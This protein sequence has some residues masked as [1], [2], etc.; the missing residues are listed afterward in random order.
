MA[1][2]VDESFEVAAPPERVWAY[3][4]DP[5]RV[6]TCLPGAELLEVVDERTFTGRVKIKVGPVSA[7]FRGRATFDEIDAAAR[8]VRMSGK[9]QEMAGAGSATMTMTSEVAAVGS[10]SSHVKVS[11]QV[12]VVGRLMQFGRGMMEE[13]SRQVFSQFAGCVRAT[14]E[15]E[16]SAAAGMGAAASGAGAPSGG[17][18]RSESLDALPLVWRSMRNRIGRL[19]GSRGGDA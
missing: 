8:R 17:A 15:S 9:G 12:E 1:I 3:L 16:A 4:I 7:S 18:E 2:T 14:L 10:A 13:V 11:A 5:A 6:V 19:F